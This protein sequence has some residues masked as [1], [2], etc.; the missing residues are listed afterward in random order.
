MA[1]GCE[2]VPVDLLGYC[3]MPNHFHLLLRPHHDGDLGR[4]MQWLLTAHVRRYHRHYGTSIG[5]SRKLARAS[6]Q[7]ILE[8]YTHREFAELM[9]AVEAIS[10]MVVPLG[11][12]VRQH[13]GPASREDNI[14]DSGNTTTVGQSL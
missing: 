6:C 4:W 13:D 14:N 12:S 3:L 10:V 1:Q 9:V 2:R 7:A 11:E 8:R 5:L